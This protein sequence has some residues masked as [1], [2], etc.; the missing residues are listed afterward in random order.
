MTAFTGRTSC[1]THTL[2][3]SRSVP[4]HASTSTAACRCRR[5]SRNARRPSSSSSN[6]PSSFVVVDVVIVVVV[7]IE[8]MR[9]AKPRRYGAKSLARSLST[10]I[11][12]STDAPAKSGSSYDMSPKVI[13]VMRDDPLSSSSSLPSSSTRTVYSRLSG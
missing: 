2:S 8:V 9:P 13:G 5:P 11:S 1:G 12:G 3:N 10:K 6:P 7:V 4:S